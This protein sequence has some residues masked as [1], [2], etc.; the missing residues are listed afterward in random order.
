ME[1]WKAEG[2]GNRFGRELDAWQWNGWRAGK[3]DSIEWSRG[4]KWSLGNI[5]M[6]TWR[7][8]KGVIEVEDKGRGV[9]T[10]GGAY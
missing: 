10:L 5:W 6:S 3:H 7:D 1:S 2:F 8:G 9:L 4:G